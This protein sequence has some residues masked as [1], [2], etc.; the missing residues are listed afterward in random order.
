MDPWRSSPQ[1]HSE[2]FPE[3]VRVIWS[4][5]HPDRVKRR[6]GELLDVDMNMKTEELTHIRDESGTA[7]NANLEPPEWAVKYQ[8]TDWREPGF[9]DI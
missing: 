7:G 6:R 1:Q 5:P 9:A 4:I 2:G 3:N 8:T